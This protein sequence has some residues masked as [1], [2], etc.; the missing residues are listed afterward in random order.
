MKQLLTMKPFAHI[1]GGEIIY[2]LPV[3]VDVKIKRTRWVVKMRFKERLKR[4][5]GGF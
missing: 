3:H 5:L 2:L 4:F 1:A